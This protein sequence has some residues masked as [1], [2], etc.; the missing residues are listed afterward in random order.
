VSLDLEQIVGLLNALPPDQR[1]I[2]ERAAIEHTK[3]R[4]WVPNP[5]FQE[6]AYRSLADELFAGGEPGGGKSILLVGTAIEDHSSSIIFRREYPQIK[7]LEDTA[8][9]ILGSRKGYNAQTHIWRFAPGKTMEFGSVPHE[10]DKKRYQGRPHPLKGF[11]EITH[12]TRSQYKYLTLWNRPAPGAANPNERRRII[13]TGNPPT[14]PEGLWVNEYWKPWLDRTYHDPAEP[15]ELRWATPA[16]DDSDKE[17][18]FRSLEEAVD[19]IRESLSNPAF[20]EKDGSVKPPRSRTFVPLP[21]EENRDYI[22]SGYSSVLG[23]ASKEDRA[24]AAGDFAAGIEDHPYQVIPTAWIVA[25]Q[26]RWTPAP[27]KGAP[28]TAI[29]VDVAQGG[30]DDTVLAPR[31]DYW[32]AELIAEP[33]AKTP[34]PSDVAAL[35][36]RHRRDR[37]AVI[38]DCGGGYGAGVVERL[39]DNSIAAVKFLGSAAG[40]GRTKCRTYGFANKRA[41]AHWRFREALDPDQPGGS[42]IQL[43]N[44]PG[45][46]SDLAAARFEITTRNEIRIEDKEEIKKRIG[47]SPDKG[48]AVIEAWDEANTAIRRGVSGPGSTGGWSRPEVQGLTLARRRRR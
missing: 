26:E 10:K 12:F 41:M 27:P 4:V 8:E 15:G 23:Y 29:G 46:R 31:H 34:M 37:A 11:D 39:A 42:P 30:G 7:G 9:A 5:G 1:E 13:A 33:G 19:Y 32:Y 35:V 36:V 18:F 25:A 38:V 16:D 24:M 48:D 28:M 45:L 47:R 44:D 40:I 6:M 14:S 3:K 2:V 22:R 20:F 43:P 21:L 17:R